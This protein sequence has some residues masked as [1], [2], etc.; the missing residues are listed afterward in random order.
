MNSHEL[1][2][3]VSNYPATHTIFEGVFAC[4]RLPRDISYP[5]A[6]ICNTHPSNREGEHWVCIYID[7]NGSGE[8]FDSYGLAP[9]RKEFMHFLTTHCLEWTFN[10][11]TVQPLLS[12]TC[13]LYCAYYTIMRCNGYSTPQL[14]ALFGSDL[15]FNNQLVVRFF[16]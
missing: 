1:Q 6:F 4:D 7:A 3:L 10:E 13:G 5:S 14:L 9:I 8:Y 11:K 15:A 12:S 2:Q 16:E